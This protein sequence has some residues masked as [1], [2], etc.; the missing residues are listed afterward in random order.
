MTWNQPHIHRRPA[1]AALLILL[2]T[3]AAASF[4]SA[5]T[6]AGRVIV[7]T[8]EVFAL[9]AEGDRRP[10]ERG[11]EVYEGDTLVC[12][13]NGRLQVRF[14]DGAL[15][16]LQPDSRFEVRRY[17]SEAAGDGED[18]AVMELLKGGLRTLTG[19]IGGADHAD[20]E[21]RTPV[22]S[23]GIRGTHY[24]VR[25]CEPACLDAGG[26]TYR[27]LYGAVIEGRVAVS[28]P[29]G[30]LEFGRDAFFH[31]LAEDVAPKPVLDVPEGVLERP[32]QSGKKERGETRGKADRTGGRD[33]RRARSRDQADGDRGVGPVRPGYSSAEE[34]DRDGDPVASR[35]DLRPLRGVMAAGYAGDPDDFRSDGAPPAEG[36]VI[37]TG[38]NG[39]V[40]LDR[41]GRVVQVDVGMD[42]N[43]RELRVL[44]ARLVERGGEETFNVSWGRWQGSFVVWGTDLPGGRRVTDGQFVYAY[45]PDLTAGAELPKTGVAEY[46]FLGDGPQP[47][48]ALGGAWRVD[49]LGFEVDFDRQSMGEAELVLVNGHDAVLKLGSAGGHPIGPIGDE[50]LFFYGDMRGDMRAAD[51]RPLGPARGDLEGHFLGDAAKGA[52]V[53]YQAD[54]IGRDGPLAAIQGV[55]VLHRR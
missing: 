52:L 3:L 50:A 53:N 38:L 12:A 55:G 40:L 28:N 14:K 10:L 2:L 31:V 17:R 19:A 41:D 43:E 24:A 26:T 16:A 49:K 51:G 42:A 44:D 46:V 9:D 6:P 48:D 18:G 7:Q 27:G 4:A 22:A 54:A 21:L 35:T 47:A 45:S 13:A 34:V 15:V 5:A 39:E 23:I 37:R 25:Y 1:A 29:G 11:S 20:Y 30:S 8:G 36:G 33:T 32:A